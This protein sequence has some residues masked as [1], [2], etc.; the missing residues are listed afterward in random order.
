MKI[1]TT[2]IQTAVLL[3][4][5]LSLVPV[6]TRAQESSPYM[7][8]EVA[9]TRAPNGAIVREEVLAT[10]S[11]I[12]YLEPTTERVCRHMQAMPAYASILAI[13]I[14]RFSGV[15]HGQLECPKAR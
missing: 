10:A 5:A 15:D 3:S 9:L 14:E 8:G 1:L 4:L 12:L 2:T 11:E 7:G 13:A 6:G